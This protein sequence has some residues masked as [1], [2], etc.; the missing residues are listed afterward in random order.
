MN[1]PVSQKDFDAL[2]M[3]VA[4]LSERVKSISRV[5]LRITKKAPKKKKAS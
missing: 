5:L 3:D 1:R 4:E 2:A